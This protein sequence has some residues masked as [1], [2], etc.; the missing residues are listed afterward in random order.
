MDRFSSRSMRGSNSKFGVKLPVSRGFSLVE[1]LV[2]IALIG[3]LVS[4]LLPAIQGAREAARRTGCSNNLKQIGIALHNFHDAKQ[5]FPTQVTGSAPREGG[6]GS[7]FYSWMIPILPL[8]EEGTLYDSIDLN[9]GMMDTCDQSSPTD[10]QGLTISAD[11]PNAGAAA[12]RVTTFLCPSDW[13]AD[14]VSLGTA[15]PAPGSYVGNI[16][17]VQGTT[18][19]AGASSP[20]ARSNGFFG[21]ENPKLPDPWQQSKVRMKHFSDGLAHTAALSERL[22]TS[23]QS[24]PD[25]GVF[26]ALPADFE[27]QPIALQS[28]CGGS[29]GP[30]RSLATW[31]TYCGSVSHGDPRVS[32]THG[33]SWISGWTYSANT[34]MHVMPINERNCHLYG[35]EHSG[36]NVVTP[37]SQHPGGVH[38]VMGDGSVHFI[39]ES[40]E[41]S[42]WWSMGSRDGG[43]TV[44]RSGY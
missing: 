38:V 36:A 28:Y 1:L 17:W 26:G 22:I 40:I 41:M 30:N 18:G 35:G 39:S 11:H 32:N 16:G 43:E 33:R 21:L 23:N 4:L 14:S 12:T 31:V 13:Y 29:V 24:L 37:S 25:A 6:C 27:R 9:R 44:D 2:V 19:I 34:Y 10:Y 8:I 42:V 5:R 20:I 7:G 15:R 3:V